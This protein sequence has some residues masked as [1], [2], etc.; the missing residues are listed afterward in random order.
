MPNGNAA[1]IGRWLHRLFEASL[2]AKGLLAAAETAA[3]L[4][5]WLTANRTFHTLAAW[6]TRTELSEDPTDPMA[7]WFLR[8]AGAVSI[9]SQHFY[10][11][12]L[13]SHGLL[14]LAMVGGLALRLRWAYPASM[15]VLAGFVVYQ[16]H[17]WT[18]TRSPT[19]VML[20]LFDLVMICLVWRE[21]RRLKS[22]APARP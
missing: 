7:R 12:Y 19:L 9:E 13:L 5:L 3:G 8:A 4:G 16:M 22:H 21:W 17:H 11:I 2:L 15:A 1:P 18:L 10:A 14:K 20:S 6:L